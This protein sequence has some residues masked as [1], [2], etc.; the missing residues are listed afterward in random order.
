MDGASNGKRVAVVEGDDTPDSLRYG[1]GV[2]RLGVAFAALG[3]S[4]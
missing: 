4:R 1:C 3:L 2:R